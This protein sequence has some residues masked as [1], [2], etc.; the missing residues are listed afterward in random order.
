[1]SSPL[2][3]VAAL[4]ARVQADGAQPLLTCYDAADGSRVEFSARTFANWVDKTA[5]LI[6]SL[7]LD[8]GGD[9]GLPLLLTHPGH[10]VGLVW[11]MATWQVGGRVL[12][13]PRDDLDRV[14]LAVVGPQRAHPVPGVETVVCSL[15]PLGAGL[16]TPVPGVTDYA[17]VLSQPD[18][19]WRND[20]PDLWLDDGERRVTT[21]ELGTLGPD[22]G[23]R[24]VQPC[25]DVWQ[26]L[27]RM[28]ICPLLGGGSVVLVRGDAAPAELARIVEA[29]RALP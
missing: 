11:A 26:D 7:G 14:E 8:E 17:E 23:R 21:A 12:A 18:V 19:H 16:P 6:G 25:G 3:P 13:L 4:E 27:S 5:N 22:A 15:H 2:D 9:I 10:W 29:E 24:L 28:L 1:M 20:A